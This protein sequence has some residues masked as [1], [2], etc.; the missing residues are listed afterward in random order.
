MRKHL[1]NQTWGQTWKLDQKW[2]QNP[3]FSCFHTVLSSS[4]IYHIY[5]SL[6]LI[7]IV[8]N[9]SESFLNVSLCSLKSCLGVRIKYLANLKLLVKILFS[10]PPENSISYLV[11]LKKNG[12][13]IPIDSFYA[14][15][16]I[17]LVTWSFVE[18]EEKLE[19][20]LKY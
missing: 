12:T 9:I 5:Y 6:D 2:L 10:K 18:N 8:D 20:L 19:L 14:F 11:T 15:I 7:N 16:S 4:T 1:Q 13:V 3:F 17:F